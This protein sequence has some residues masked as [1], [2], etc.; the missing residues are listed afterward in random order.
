MVWLD[1]Y[2]I[3]D[4]NLPTVGDYGNIDEANGSSMENRDTPAVGDYGY[5]DEAQSHGKQRPPKCR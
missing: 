3:Q 2:H 5:I 4:R 1:Q